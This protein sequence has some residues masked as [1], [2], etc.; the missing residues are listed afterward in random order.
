MDFFDYKL[1]E[2]LIDFFIASRKRILAKK[3]K[4]NFDFIT[5][6]EKSHVI[7]SGF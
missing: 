4:E 6:W 5:Y 2:M 1:P 7:S 3:R